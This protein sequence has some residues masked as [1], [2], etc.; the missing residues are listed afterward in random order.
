MKREVWEGKVPVSFSVADEEVGFN[1]S[2]LPE[3]CYV[4]L[5]ELLDNSLSTL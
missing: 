1:K 2:N 5:S 3:P 4:S